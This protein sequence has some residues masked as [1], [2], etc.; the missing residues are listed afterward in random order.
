MDVSTNITASNTA[1]V[2]ASRSVADAVATALSAFG[3]GGSNS[4]DSETS[5]A[6]AASVAMGVPGFVPP[7]F[8]GN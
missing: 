3:S 6:F 2:Y 1:T 5:D 7:I 4:G 8:G